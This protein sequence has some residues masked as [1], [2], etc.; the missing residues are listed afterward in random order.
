MPGFL[1]GGD[2]EKVYSEFI[3]QIFSL[4][5]IKTHGTIFKIFGI[6]YGGKIS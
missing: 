4:S 1:K 2:M 3:V 6:H 5:G